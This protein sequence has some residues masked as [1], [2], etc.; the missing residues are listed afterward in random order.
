MR[1]GGGRSPWMV[2]KHA[3]WVRISRG[4]YEAWSQLLW[5]SFFPFSLGLIRKAPNATQ[6]DSDMY[7][8][9]FLE[10]H[11]TSGNCSP[12]WSGLG[13]FGL[14]CCIQCVGTKYA[15]VCSLFYRI[16]LLIILYKWHTW[17]FGGRWPQ[18]FC[19]LLHRDQIII[20]QEG[21]GNEGKFFCGRW[22]RLF[23][24]KKTGIYV[25]VTFA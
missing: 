14:C 18:E 19:W 9:Q 7:S 24:E 2:A 6:R 4:C 21:K 17:L 25:V 13:M 12:A 15:A 1:D 3:S 22:R 23:S 11:C 8:F 10:S 5:S 20:Q 16:W